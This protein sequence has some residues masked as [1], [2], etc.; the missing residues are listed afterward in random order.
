LECIAAGYS[1]ERANQPLG[2]AGS[3]SHFKPPA[4]QRRRRRLIDH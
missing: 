1:I 2:T 3:S 4:A